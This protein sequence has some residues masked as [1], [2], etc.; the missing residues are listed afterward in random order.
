MLD[1]TRAPAEMLTL[2]LAGDVMTGRGIDQLLAHPGSPA[3]DEAGVGDAREYL[4]M[5]E[6]RSGALPRAV[7]NRYVWGDALQ[8]IEDAGVQLRIAN[9]ETA[10]TTSDEAWPGKAV[11][12]RMNPSNVGVLASGALD[13]CT[14]ANNHVL[15]WGRPGLLQTL[16]TLREAGI[17]TAGAGEDGEAAWAPASLPIGLGRRLLVFSC[18][19]S[20]SGVPGGWT[21]GPR[22]SGIA[23]LPDL[24][25]STARDLAADA[26]RH[27]RGD[28]IVVVSIHWGPNWGLQVPRE[29]RHF[30]RRLI[31]L[32]AADVV[33]GHSS[34]HPLPVEVYRGK[35]ILYGCGDLIND[36]E[37]IETRP[38]NP[39]ADVACLYL[40]RLDRARGLLR[41]LEVVPMQRFRMRLVHADREAREWLH[42]LFNEGGRD[43][44]TELVAQRD[45]PW[46]LQWGR[47]PVPA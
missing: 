14:L 24:S 15:D 10:V 7:S 44:G 36:Y 23:R 6:R 12:Y 17:A 46:V 34:H 33:H 3:I 37:G 42:T 39:R 45:G 2:L 30:A 26:A 25:D 13:C 47:A 8:A 18:A 43:L 9:L 11:R 29:H 5:A 31:D 32:G 16:Q 20:D 28:G 19:T 38:G 35:L 40:A 1:V 21:A 41:R 22:Q 27:R 4:R